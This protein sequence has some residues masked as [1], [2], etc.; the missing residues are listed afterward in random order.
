MF[1][2]AS[3]VWMFGVTLWEMFTYGQEPWL[4]Y[5]GA[6]ILHKIDKENERLSQPDNCPDHIYRLMLNCWR[7][8]PDQRPTFKRIKEVIPQM[9]PKELVATCDLN[10]P[11]RLKIMKGDKITVIRGRAENHWWRGQNKR[12]LEVGVFPRLVTSSGQDGV[13]SRDDISKPLKNS[14]IHTGHGDID[15]AR[16]WG[17]PERIDDLYLGNPMEPPDLV[18]IDN[19]EKN[20]SAEDESPPGTS[21]RIFSKTAKDKYKKLENSV[22]SKIVWK[23]PSKSKLPTSMESKV[24][25]TNSAS[26]R[27]RRR[28]SA[29]FP[30]SPPAK[31]EYS[32]PPISLTRSNSQETPRVPSVLDESLSQSPTKG[33]SLP[34][35]IKPF[36]AADTFFPQDN[37][38]KNQ[39][40]VGYDNKAANLAE[41]DAIPMYDEVEPDR[42]DSK[43][44]TEYAWD[45]HFHDDMENETME[46]VRQALQLSSMQESAIKRSEQDIYS[47]FLSDSSGTPPSAASS[48]LGNSANYS[49]NPFCATTSDNNTSP[50][51][52]MRSYSVGLPAKSRS[53]QPQ[54]KPK[55]ELKPDAFE[56]LKCEFLKKY[57]LDKSSAIVTADL[58]PERTNLK[59]NSPTTAVKALYVPEALNPSPISISPRGASPVVIPEPIV[60]TIALQPSNLSA[61]VAAIASKYN[62]VPPS[63]RTDDNHPVVRRSNSVNVQPTRVNSWSEA[64]PR[65]PPR[66][67]TRNNV[68]A[69][70]ASVPVNQVPS[71]RQQCTTRSIFSATPSIGQS[72]PVILPIIR[73]GKKLSSTHYYLL[74]EDK[75][76]GRN[77]PRAHVMP[78]SQTTTAHNLPAYSPATTSNIIHP[79]QS[80]EQYAA[81][82]AVRLNYSHMRPEDKMK[83]L[84]KE[85]FGVTDEQCEHAL[86]LNSWDVCKA[87]KYLKIE[88]LFSIGIA[89]R[90]RCQQ[91][92]QIMNWNLETSSNVLFQEFQN[93]SSH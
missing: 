16:S 91:I 29:D 71:T 3:D 36:Y 10:E 23:E 46:G 30:A 5:N 63:S 62:Y 55:I 33:G 2:H 88:Q 56:D 14:F 81:S 27:N 86:K 35:P 43:S 1:S 4:S 24:K 44:S 47:A 93:N 60:P 42:E 40:K 61:S 68:G 12:T 57:Q 28:N 66:E 8:Q 52:R 38:S 26:S 69:G 19:L 50:G 92:L 67:P 48:S 53:R 37:D 64:P 78:F 7:L 51:L 65:I 77:V 15:P 11:D 31:N 18:A 75:N 6:Q 39:W 84:Q 89:P 17:F 73:D 80:R 45:V 79:T 82:V 59:S 20:E 74:P 76:S 22:R 21:K 90:D 83:E 58:F 72:H 85:V 70:Y 25:T 13:V 32:H 34:S 49:H 9:F 54:Q 41:T 87:I